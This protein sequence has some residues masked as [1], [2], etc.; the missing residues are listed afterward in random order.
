MLGSDLAGQL[1]QGGF[2]NVVCVLS[3][4]ST[5]ML[6]AISLKPGVDCALAKG[7]RPVLLMRTL[8]E[9]LAAKRSASVA[10]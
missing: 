5:E 8:R 4:S 7:V 10:G 1:Q 6:D 3:G 9:K 2:R